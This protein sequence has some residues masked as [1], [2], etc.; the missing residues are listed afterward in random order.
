MMSILIKDVKPKVKVGKNIC[1]EVK[2]EI[3]IVQ[4]DC[5]SAVLSIYFLAKSINPTPP[6][7]DHRY[8]S[9]GTL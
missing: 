1:E 9:T 3:G 2:T 8:V 4:G 5:L 7:T 6:D